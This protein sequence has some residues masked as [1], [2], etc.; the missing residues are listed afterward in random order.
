[1]SANGGSVT[2]MGA[3]LPGFAPTW[4]PDGSHLALV[5]AYENC[6]TDYPCF[7]QHL[8]LVATSDG[9]NVRYVT[10]GDQPAWKPHP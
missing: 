4:S 9:S 8:I 10:A 3:G 6:D 7:T 5:Q 2:R 1:M